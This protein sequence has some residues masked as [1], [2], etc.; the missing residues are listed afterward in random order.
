MR[1]RDGG[2]QRP[3]EVDPVHLVFPFESLESLQERCDALSRRCHASPVIEDSAADRMVAGL[4]DEGPV[5]CEEGGA[6]VEREGWQTCTD[7]RVVGHRSS[8]VLRQDF[9][10]QKTWAIV[11]LDEKT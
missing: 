3:N 5:M 9:V 4:S 8:Q 7:S 11:F 10:L 1:Q 2:N 6:A